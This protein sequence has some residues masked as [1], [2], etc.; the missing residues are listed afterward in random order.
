MVKRIQNVICQIVTDI[1]NL[2]LIDKGL[3]KYVNKFIVRMQNP[4]TSEEK[5]R[6]ENLSNKVAVVSD[7]MNLLSDIEDPTT[8]LK[9]LKTLLSNVIADSEV[10]QLLTDEIEKLE[11]SDE[12]IDEIDDT[13]IDVDDNGSFSIGGISSGSDLPDFGSEDFGSEEQSTDE[14][15]PSPEDLGIDMTDSSNPEFD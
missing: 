14:E 4:T 2:M 15:L 13:D 12:A 3:T 5:D 6:R 1:V 11:N 7:I 10:I 8:K 9:I